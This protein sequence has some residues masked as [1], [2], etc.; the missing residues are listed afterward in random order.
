VT[1]LAKRLERVVDLRGRKY[2][3][4]LE[5]GGVITFRR[6]RSPRRLALSLPLGKVLT[7]AELAAGE[8]V[9]AE[10]AAARAAKKAARQ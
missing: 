5:P 2:V 4:A 8:R 6:L 9:I 7:R 10:R 1:P 3:V